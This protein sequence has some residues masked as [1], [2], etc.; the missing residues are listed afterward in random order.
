[1]SA[2][3]HLAASEQILADQQPQDAE[4]AGYGPLEWLILALA[5]GV[6]AIA[7]ELGVPGSTPHTAQGSPA[8]SA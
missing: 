5:H 4:A 3:D 7:I 6:A 1:M 2:A 8:S